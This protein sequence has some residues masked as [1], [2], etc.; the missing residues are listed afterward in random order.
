M[1][2]AAVQQKHAFGVKGDVA[3][4]IAYLDEQ[5]ILYPT[6]STCVLYNIDLKSQKFISCSTS[7]LGMTA[8]VSY[9]S[10]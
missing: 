7:S 3:N 1:S 4:N 6:G 8:I 9:Y 2:I 5:N 10:R